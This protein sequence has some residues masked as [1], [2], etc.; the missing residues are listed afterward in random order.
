[1]N[2]EEKKKLAINMISKWL[3]KSAKK[4][5]YN[6]G[7]ELLI[8]FADKVNKFETV[9]ECTNKCQFYEVEDCKSFSGYKRLIL[10]IEVAIALPVD[11]FTDG[12]VIDIIR[13][14]I[15]NFK[16]DI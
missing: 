13:N 7:E 6:T 14:L 12:D 9:E 3:I 15:N 11:K 8:A 1:M 2:I 4:R 16:K 5:D 10:E